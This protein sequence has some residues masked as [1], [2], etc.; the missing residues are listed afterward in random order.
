[1]KKN[2]WCKTI[3]CALL[4]LFSLNSCSSDVEEETNAAGMGVVS[5]MVEADAGFQTRAVNE[6]DYGNLD[7]YTVQ[8]L[9]NGGVVEE[10][11][12]AELPEKVELKNGR[13][14]LKAFY[15]E[16][17]PASSK[18]MYVEGSTEFNV[19]GDNT[20]QTVNCKPV[21]A[22]LRIEYD[23]A[24]KN[25]F[26]SNTATVSGTEAMGEATYSL[27]ENNPLYIKVKEE[28]EAVKVAI[29]LVQKENAQTITITRDYSLKPSQAKLIKIA[30]QKKNGDLG[31]SIKV[32]ESTNDR[33]LDIEV[34]E[35]WVDAENNQ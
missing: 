14:V 7:N 9:Q 26:S 3:V 28:G 27:E 22:R 29:M 1:M 20:T 30:P 11:K 32:D 19:N 24:M 6:S 12:Y 21:C 18:S 8:I 5:L 25:Y 4:G 15:G 10:W 23:A 16:D 17:L 31:I 33:P 34:P 2:A 35:D 13:Y